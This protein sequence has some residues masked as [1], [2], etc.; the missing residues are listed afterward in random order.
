MTAAASVPPFINVVWAASAGGAYITNPVPV[1]SQQGIKN[2]AAS[3]TDGYPPNTFLPP[4]SGGAGPFGADMNGV[5]N[6]IA[7]DIQWLQAGAIYPYNAAFQAA[8]GGYPQGARVQSAATIGLIWYSLVDN[9]TTDPDTGGAGWLALIRRFAITGSILNLY[10]SPS[11][12][13][14]NSGL[15]I[16]S[17]WQTL[18]Y[19]QG[20]IEDNLDGM[21]N[22][23]IVN[24]ANGTYTSGINANGVTPG[25][26][27]QQA[28]LY[29]GGS[30]AIIS[31]TNGPAVRVV[32][33]S[34]IALSGCTLQSN[35]ATG[36]VQGAVI[37][38]S[39]D[40]SLYMVGGTSI[41]AVV[42]G[43]ASMQCLYGGN[44]EIAGTVT[45]T[46]DATSVAFASHAGV[47]ES[48]AELI[49]SGT[50]TFSNGTLSSTNNGLIDWSLGSWS[51]SA[52]SSVPY[53]V[54]TGGGLQTNGA[55]SSIPGSGS[56]SVTSPG[57]AA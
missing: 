36:G 48:S 27:G 43:W 54:A 20:W 19:A 33:G 15:A 45:V 2:G 17:P 5:L 21:G 39:L 56:A 29:T 28:I 51:G 38:I 10:V 18:T 41:G 42:S 13:N 23:V 16:G 47:I 34:T 53:L 49:L 26:T 52:G 57:W 4:A 22:Q 7:A 44:I 25:L 50:R 11:G 32:Y 40:G 1:P 6:Q 55:L 30:G 24:L 9:N 12:S 37:S 3:W 35:A 14:S 31:P 8:I 46:A